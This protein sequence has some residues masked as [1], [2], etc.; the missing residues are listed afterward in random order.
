MEN[1]KNVSFSICSDNKHV[2]TRYTSLSNKASSNSAKMLEREVI[3]T[4]GILGAV[5]P[6]FLYDES[7][8]NSKSATSSTIDSNTL[9]MKLIED[10]KKDSSISF[11]SKYGII[12]VTHL[13]SMLE[14]PILR[15]K[16]SKQIC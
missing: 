5:D 12:V 15:N 13:K 9:E 1:L 2:E 14:N 8:N 4:I 7:S 10:A 3:R 6:A 16:Y 11:E